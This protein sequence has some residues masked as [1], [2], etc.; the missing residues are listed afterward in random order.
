MHR[1]RLRAVIALYLVLQAC[2]VLAPALRSAPVVGGIRAAAGDEDCC[3]ALHPGK[4]CPMGH[5][6]RP[7]PGTPRLSCGCGDH[8]A[9]F[10]VGIA[11]P[12]PMPSAVGPS[13]VASPASLP[14]AAAPLDRPRHVTLPP[15][16]A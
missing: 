11:Y 8:D 2:A 3:A 10:P 15:P 5:R 16:R 7:L 9:L 1:E 12:G 4:A 13:P 14:A 6:A